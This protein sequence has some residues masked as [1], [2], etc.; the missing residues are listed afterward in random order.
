MCAV[1]ST[2]S[3][4]I[5]GAF[6]LGGVLVGGIITGGT[7]WFSERRILKREARVGAQL[8]RRE[9][10][11]A[12]RSISMGVKDRTWG[13]TR[14]LATKAWD[15]HQPALSVALKPADWIVVASAIAYIRDQTLPMLEI[16]APGWQSNVVPLAEEYAEGLRPLW[17]DCR[18]AFVALHRA[19]QAPSSFRDLGSLEA[20]LG[21]Q[22]AISRPSPHRHA[23][24]GGPILLRAIREKIRQWWPG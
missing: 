9:L 24:A 5:T 16:Q 2:E 4:W 22:A 7:G 6:G 23:Q 14:S 11:T 21:E 13:P 8:L 18:K 17:D 10:Q 19:S 12:T 20:Q 1:M 3:Q 15:E